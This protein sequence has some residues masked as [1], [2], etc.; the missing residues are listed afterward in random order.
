MPATRHAPAGLCGSRISPRWSI[1]SDASIWPA[2]THTMKLAAVGRDTA[3]AQ[4]ADGEIDLAL[5]MFPNSPTQI[6][7][8]TL[9]DGHFVSIADRH[10][11]PPRSGLPLA[12]WLARPHVLVAGRTVDHAPRDRRLRAFTPPLDLPRFAFQQAWH[13]RRDADAAHCW[14]RGLVKA[15]SQPGSRATGV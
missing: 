10:S 9:F 12:Q 13:A 2:M 3:M 8:Q 14:F 11:L 7:V 5:G 4:L 15:C 6:K 1:A